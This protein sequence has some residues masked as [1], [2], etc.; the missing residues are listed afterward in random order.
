M[1]AVPRSLAT[2]LLRAWSGRADTVVFDEPLLPPYIMIEGE[3]FGFTR[4]DVMEGQRETDWRKVV[5]ELTDPLL[6]GKRISYTK[7]QPHNLIPEVMGIAWLE[8]FSNCFLIREPKDMLLSLHNIVPEFTF[9]ETG[10]GELKMLFDHFHEQ[11]GVLPPVIDAQELQNAPHRILTQL[12][13]AVGVDFSDK[14]LSWP[15]VD[16][17]F[18]PEK[19]KAWYGSVLQSTHFRPYQPKTDPLPTHLMDVYERCNEIYQELY[20]VRLR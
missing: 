1:W 6:E 15:T 5:A 16:D 12:C 4:D 18:L 20:A 13:D 7:L 3:D 17:T 14:M 19:E 8:P 10:W 11:N 9:E 2:A